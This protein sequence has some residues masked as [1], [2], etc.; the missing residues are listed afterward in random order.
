MKSRKKQSGQAL[1]ESALIL[2][3]FL[4]LFIGI[5]DFGQFFY[6]YQSLTDRARAGAR[7]GSVIACPDPAGCTP[8]VN[9][10]I[11]NAPTVTGSALLPCLAGECTTNATVTAVVA[12]SG[13]QS[14]RI[15]VT[16]SNYPF[17]F[18][19]PFFQKSVWTI[20]ATEPYEFAF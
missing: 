17:N 13:T 15:T 20:K 2:L 5:V 12:G 11:Y 4:V 10:T 8:A 18:I 14:G 19:L 3:I 7:Y 16:I 1:V 6:F 9:Y